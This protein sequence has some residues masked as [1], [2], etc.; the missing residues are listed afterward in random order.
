MG[1]YACRSSNVILGAA[2]TA[3]AARTSKCITNDFAANP[4]AT[5]W[6]I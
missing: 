6:K 2:R 3:V 1:K 5:L 4:A